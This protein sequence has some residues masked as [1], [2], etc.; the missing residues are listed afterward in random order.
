MLS[1]ELLKTKDFIEDYAIGQRHEYILTEHLLYGLIEAS[2]T[3]QILQALLDDVD[4]LTQ[5]LDVYLDKYV[6]KSDKSPV[7]SLACERIMQ[8]A[9]LQLELAGKD[10]LL[11]TSDVLLALL[12]EQDSYAVQLL[13]EY[14]LTRLKLRRYLAHDSEISASVSTAQSQENPHPLS[15]FAHNLN[16]KAQE[17]NIDPLIGREAEMARIIQILCRRRKNN[18]LLIGDAGVGKT[19]LAEGLAWRIVNGNIAAPLQDAVVY[20]LDITALIAGTKYRGEFEARMKQVLNALKDDPQAILFIDEVHTIVGAGSVSEGTMDISNLIKPALANGELR[21]IGSTTFAECRQIF[22]KDSALSRRFQKVTVSEPSVSDAIAILQG[23]AKVYADFH[24]VTYTKAALTAAVELSVKHMHERY[25]PDKAIDVIDEAGAYLRLQ[26]K[27]A[28]TRPKVNVAHIE[29]VIANLARIPPKTVARDDL[30][31]LQNL[32][33]T[34]KQAVFG[35]DE[36]VVKVSD[37]IMLAR[38][39]LNNANRPIGAFLFAGPTGVGKTEIAKQLAKTLGVAFVRFD[40]SEYVEAHSVARLI[41]APPGYIGYEKGGLLTE[42]IQQTPH[43]VLLLDEIEKAHSDI[44]NILLQV[45]DN[46]KLTDANGRTVSFAET[47]IIMTSNVGAESLARA[48]MGF[49]EQNHTKDNIATLNRAFSPEFRN[50]LDAIIQFN[51]LEMSTILAVVDKFLGQLAELLQAKKVA[52]TV[53]KEAKQYLADTGY[54]RL[55]GA[56]PMARLIDSAIKKPLAHEL[57]F[58]R[59]QDGGQVC[60]DY[61]AETLTLDIKKATEGKI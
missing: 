7:Y 47:I 55:M 28:T 32:E 38:A 57:L 31:A 50:R 12:D 43:A 58:G 51:P 19:A 1:A 56:R 4:E 16:T 42:K 5:R 40:M 15:V 30:S 14:G 20:S 34:L 24:H 53:T 26:S 29:T 33:S 46:A 27:T 54:D 59:L 13:E 10:A 37:A 60:V 25:L 36:A 22:D 35:Q 48:S 41:G 2:S 61:Q 18:P 52:L 9:L 21:C 45:M 44:Y 8:R 17:G 49:T 23:V 3:K 6:S 11:Q 39:G